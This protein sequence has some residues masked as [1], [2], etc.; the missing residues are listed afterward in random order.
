VG[1]VVDARGRQRW[2]RAVLFAR[3]LEELVGPVAV[4]GIV[5]VAEEDVREDARAE[6]LRVQLSVRTHLFTT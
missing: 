1:R 6:P 2:Q 3:A 5:D 4:P